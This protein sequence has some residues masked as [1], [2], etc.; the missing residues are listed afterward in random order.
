M[1]SSLRECLDL[2]RDFNFSIN[3]LSEKE[4]GMF[5]IKDCGDY[6]E[7]KKLIIEYSEIKLL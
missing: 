7:A 3:L 2:R 6:E 1:S 4:R 5:E